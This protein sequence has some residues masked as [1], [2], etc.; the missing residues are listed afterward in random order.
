MMTF[1][2]AT[3]PFPWRSFSPRLARP[4]LA[5]ALSSLGSSVA[6]PVA[7]AQTPTQ[8]DQKDLTRTQAA[9]S[10]AKEGLTLLSGPRVDEG[11]TKID[12]SL[13]TLEFTLG[14]DHEFVVALR[15]VLIRFYETE[16]PDPTKKQAVLDR[17]QRARSSQSPSPNTPSPTGSTDTSQAEQQLKAAMLAF[18]AH[19]YVLALQLFEQALPALP[20]LDSNLKMKSGVH[21][22]WARLYDFNLRYDQAERLLTELV[23]EIEQEQGPSSPLL[24]EPLYALVMHYLQRNASAEMLKYAQKQV[25]AISANQPGSTRH[26]EALLLRAIAH[27]NTHQPRLALADL[28]EAKKWMTQQAK[29]DAAQAVELLQTMRTVHWALGDKKSAVLMSRSACAAGQAAGPGPIRTMTLDNCV[30]TALLDQKFPTAATLLKDKL[31]ALEERDGP[32]PSLVWAETAKQLARVQVLL[33][34]PEAALTLYQRVARLEEDRMERELLTGSERQKREK[35]GVYQ[36]TLHE[37][38]DLGGAQ[39]GTG[40]WQQLGL[41]L[42]LERKGRVLDIEARQ[43]QAYRTVTD[44]ATRKLIDR[45]MQVRA[46]MTGLSLKGETERHGQG[47]FSTQLAELQKEDE[48]LTRRLSEASDAY[49]RQTTP[50]TVESVQAALEKNTALIEYTFYIRHDPT[51]GYPIDLRLV[52]YLLTAQGPARAVELGDAGAIL[53]AVSATRRVVGDPQADPQSALDQLTALIWAPVAAHLPTHIERV[54]L[55]P[56][57]SLNLVPFGALNARDGKYL[58]HKYE[59]DY[60]G[61]GRDL[62]RRWGD[63]VARTASVV[64]GSPDF[65]R[66]LPGAGGARS[67]DLARVVF[68]PLPGT[69]EESR[70]IA[71][72]LPQAQLRLHERADKATMMQLHGPSVLHVATHG[73]FLDLPPLDIESS[74]GFNITPEL[75]PPPSPVEPWRTEDPLIRSGLALT[76]ANTPGSAAGILSALEVTGIDLGGTGL[77]VL[78]A[79]ETAVGST[80]SGRGVYGLRRALT[81]AGSEAQVMSLWKVDDSAT[82]DL[83]IA[84]YQQLAQG[85]GRGAALRTAQLNL[86]GDVKRRHPYYWA[87]F[88]PSGQYGPMDF[89]FQAPVPPPSAELKSASASSTP[90]KTRNEIYAFARR[91]KVAFGARGVRIENLLVQPNRTGALGT[92]SWEVPLL[93]NLR[94]SDHPGLAFH[95]AILIELALGTVVSPRHEYSSGKKESVWAMSYQGGYELGLGFAT[96][97]VSLM[98]GLRPTYRGMR[99]GDVRQRAFSLPGFGLLEIRMGEHLLVGRGWYGTLLGKQVVFGA[100]GEFDW[101]DDWFIR[102]Q[103]EQ[104]KYKTQVGV[105]SSDDKQSAARQI[106]STVSLSVGGFI[107]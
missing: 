59:L 100:S 34:Q 98:V 99:V 21:T 78:S 106:A 94:E 68:P 85:T 57:D 12:D 15:K 46:L 6:T 25:V 79:C 36:Q 97:P 1:R 49:R 77:V 90:A 10:Q 9:H 63:Q 73:F 62:A 74:R 38:L 4:L 14:P 23:T 50:I 53:K 47:E 51:T 20:M 65:A 69:E 19:D 56:D 11:L 60:L 107:Q 24:Q 3:F 67:G 84:L 88:I 66:Q 44:P 83:M 41:R 35:F 48:E 87:A 30:Q 26:T 86:L 29:P 13:N 92:V 75:P 95:D 55:A 32:Y 7:R 33:N 82:R 103:F 101:D 18:A 96:L 105:S 93:S 104:T 37:V 89:S 76:G 43:K 72:L 42:L 58:V 2:L 45:Q 31:R 40:A 39:D 52:A 28:N 17:E 81:I 54:L 8:V 102:G 27:V 22:I 64:V 16:R 61:S 80:D 91:S 71:Q 5:L 70:A